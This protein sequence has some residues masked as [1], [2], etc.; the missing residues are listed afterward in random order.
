MRGGRGDGR[1]PGWTLAETLIVVAIIGLLAALLIGALG[2]AYGAAVSTQCRNRL[3]QIGLAYHSHQQDHAGTWPPLFSQDPP[4]ALYERIEAETGYRMKPL[5]PAP[6]WGSPG[7]HWSI[8]LYPYLGDLSVC[9]CPADP[10]AGTT[11]RQFLDERATP[12]T[13]LEDAPPE[14]YALNAVLFRTSAGLRRQA[15]CT[16]GLAPLPDF[17][18]ITQCTTLAEQ[19]RQIPALARR[20]LFFCGAAGQTVGSQYNV[21]FRSGRGLGGTVR[22][23]WHPRLASAPFADD[24]GCGSNYLFHSGSVEY[25]DALPGLWE[26]GYELADTRR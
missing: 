16:W 23:E 8:V 13:A 10:N 24:P 6:G 15:G 1:R 7:E 9:T 25:R 21:P 20:I 17:D 11:G 18:G 4:L 3:H 22:W 19:R 14:S 26:W 5:R 12:G 2:G